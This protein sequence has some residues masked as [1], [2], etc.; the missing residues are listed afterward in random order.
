LVWTPSESKHVLSYGEEGG[1]RSRE[2][3]SRVIGDQED[4]MRGVG[5]GVTENFRRDGKGAENHRD[6]SS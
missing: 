3:L 2:N 5:V 4:E 1:G 6:T